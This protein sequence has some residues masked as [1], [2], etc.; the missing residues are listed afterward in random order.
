LKPPGILLSARLLDF[1]DGK[2]GDVGLFLV[3]SE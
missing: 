1:P 3:W 2:P